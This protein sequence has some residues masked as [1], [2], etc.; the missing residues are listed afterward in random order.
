MSLY[1]NA[2]EEEM[3]ISR[4]P[5]RISF[6]GGGSDLPVFYEEEPG[7][8]V[9]TAINKYIYIT[10]NRKFDNRIRASYSITEVVTG[11]DEL[12]HELV[13]EAI[14]MVGLDGGL[15]ITSIG[16]IPAGTGL[17]SSSAYTVGLL[18]ALYAYDGL[19]LPPRDLAEKACQIEIDI[20]GKP[21]G[22]QDQY[23]SAFGGLNYI[24]FR[25]NRVVVCPISNTEIEN[26]L[27]LF[28]IGGS[29]FAGEILA[30]QQR[31]LISDEEKRRNT[32]KMAVLAQ[33]MDTFLR[34]G[35]DKTGEFLHRNWELKKTLSPF[36][37]NEVIDRWYDIARKAGAVGGKLLGAGAGGFMLFYVPSGARVAAR[38]ALSDLRH[39]PFKFEPR[40]STI[41]YNG[42]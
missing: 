22:K 3:I 31:L 41:I 40:G 35:V 8:V 34:N 15:E 7:A 12:K 9:S 42:A 33:Q 28:Y 39:I 30:N 17:G 38:R 1:H 24:E 23:A 16:D 18:N 6:V 29:R 32:R 14:K 21:I 20:C 11:V 2:I 36:I 37:S 10:V 19:L 13:R 25:K 4:T 5:L 27:M 26:N